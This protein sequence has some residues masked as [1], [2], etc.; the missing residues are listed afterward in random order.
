MKFTETFFTAGIPLPACFP[1][2]LTLK[3]D[4]NVFRESLLLPIIEGDCSQTE[5]GTVSRGHKTWL[6]VQ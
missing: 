4:D 2:A 1:G 6:N 5:D 3:C